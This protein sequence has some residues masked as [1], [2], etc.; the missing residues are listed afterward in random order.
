[1]PRPLALI[2]D[3]DGVLVDSEPVH[4]R[5]KE[6]VFG[7]FGIVVPEAVYDSYKG[8][9]D[10]TVLGEI[11]DDRAMG[12]RLEEALQVKHQVFENLEREIQ[13]VPGAIEFVRWAR[14]RFRLA[15]A[16]SATA[17]NRAEALKLLGIADCLEAVVDAATSHRPKPDPEIF[18]IAMSKLGLKAPDCWVIEDSVYGLRAAKA[19]GC[20]AVGITTTFDRATLSQAGADLAIDSFAQLRE[21]VA[22]FEGD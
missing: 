9:P 11:L 17:R 13:P 10:A 3:K 4:K 19:A 20:V 8:R 14:T 5:A 22:R 7:Q 18:L 2:F 16:T 6:L 12:H 21:T 15:L 1:M